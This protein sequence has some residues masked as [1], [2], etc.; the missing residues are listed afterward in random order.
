MDIVNLTGRV[1]VVTGGGRGIGRAIALGLA[2][3]GAN[4]VVTAARNPQEANDVAQPARDKL[5]RDCLLAVVADVTRESDCVRAVDAARE[6]FGA[7]HILVNNAARGMR[8][9]DERF[10]ER[11]A[12]FWEAAPEA[13]RTVVD[14]NV[15]G[16][17]L[18]ARAA[19]PHLL[20]QRWGRLINI[21][22]NHETMGRA[23]FSP[24][25]PSKAAL[26]AATAAWA[27]ELDGTGVTVN[28]LLPGGI[29]DTAMVPDAA[30]EKVR[31]AMLD[32]A[33]MVAPALWLC[34][35]DADGI[36]G[37]RI[38]ANRWDPSLGGKNDALGG[39]LEP[40]RWA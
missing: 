4:V 28:A 25:G 20:A 11:P 32:P 27:R 38:V 23:G 12:K 6:R 5:G 24:Y 40:L 37:R 34:S 1:A 22:I 21:S 16:P 14:T 29:T 18:M 9:V 13:W 15:N 8:L 33:I 2:A 35:P 17:F 36:S 30:P 39:A 10:L 31:L 19:I 26:E 3:A 7:I